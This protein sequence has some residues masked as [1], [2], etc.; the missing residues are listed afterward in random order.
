MQENEDKEKCE[1]SDNPEIVNNVG[2]V[3]NEQL[4]R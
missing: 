1:I 3:Q 4:F 2:N